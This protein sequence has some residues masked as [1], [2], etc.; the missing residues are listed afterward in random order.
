VVVGDPGSGGDLSL[1]KDG[2]TIARIVLQRDGR[3]HLRS[4]VTWPRKSWPNLESAKHGAESFALVCLPLDPVLAKR[5]SKDNSTSHPWGHRAIGHCRAR[6][7]SA[8]TGSHLA[9][10]R[11]TSLLSYLGR[12]AKGEREFLAG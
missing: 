5:I 7:R 9:S 4:P 12:R 2:L 3:Y 6:K 1:Y 8:P 11:R 10:L